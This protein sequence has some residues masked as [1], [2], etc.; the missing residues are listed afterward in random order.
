MVNTPTLCTHEN[1]ETTVVNKPTLVQIRETK[2]H[3]TNIEFDV[4]TAVGRGLDGPQTCVVPKHPDGSSMFSPEIDPTQSNSGFFTRYYGRGLGE[5]TQDA[6]FVPVGYNVRVLW[7]SLHE[8]SDSIEVCKIFDNHGLL[9][10]EVDG[11]TS[12]GILFPGKMTNWT[13]GPRVGFSGTPLT[14][15]ICLFE[16]PE[17]D[18][19]GIVELLG[20]KKF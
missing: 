3:P 4:V 6:L 19:K 14:A 12:H 16:Q 20:I 17:D 9:V 1:T 11:V 13:D 18:M 8:R 5:K 2:P 7:E 15:D 10:G